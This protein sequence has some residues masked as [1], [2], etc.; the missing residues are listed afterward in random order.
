[1]LFITG[2]TYYE[3]N[4]ELLSS[5]F[6]CAEMF[7][8]VGWQPVTSFQPTPRRKSENSQV[9]VCV[10][11]CAQ[12]SSPSYIR[13]LSN[14]R[15]G[16]QGS[17]WVIITAYWYMWL[18]IYIHR[19]VCCKYIKSFLNLYRWIKSVTSQINFACCFII[20]KCRFKTFCGY[21]TEKPNIISII[22]TSNF[23]WC[24]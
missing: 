12:I 13:S 11:L 6:R 3:T 1:M 16:K 10:C 4:E 18:N 2:S 23:S 7:H 19:I 24:L 5:G 20:M 8:G 14:S 17:Y 15:I 9:S 22:I 21:I